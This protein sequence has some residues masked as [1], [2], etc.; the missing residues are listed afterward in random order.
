MTGT[1]GPTIISNITKHNCLVHKWFPFV[2]PLSLP[3]VKNVSLQP[4][5][6]K[7]NS[8]SEESDQTRQ[9]NLICR[10]VDNLLWRSFVDD[11]CSRLDTP[12]PLIL[13]VIPI[14]HDRHLKWVFLYLKIDALVKDE[15]NEIIGH[16]MVK[17]EYPSIKSVLIRSNHI[18]LKNQPLNEWI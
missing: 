13:R 12:E 8:L 3:F 18:Q 15:L 9:P 16:F 4:H 14:G 17:S 1:R 10:R 11:P 2:F 6:C 5:C 7:Q